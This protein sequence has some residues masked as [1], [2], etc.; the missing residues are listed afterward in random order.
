MLGAG[1][2]VMADDRDIVSECIERQPEVEHDAAAAAPGRRASRPCMNQRNPH[3]RQCRHQATLEEPECTLQI[4]L[5]GMKSSLC[6]MT[7]GPAARVYSLLTLW[8]PLVDQIVLA[9]DTEGDIAT[10]EACGGLADKRFAFE[11]ED[12]WSPE[13]PLAWLHQQCDGEWMIQVD[14]D[15]IP[16]AAL[17]RT[18]PELLEDTMARCVHTP[19]RWL[20]PDAQHY[21]ADEPWAPD[22]HVRILRN[23]PG[24]FLFTG[25]MHT[26]GETMG[27]RRFSEHLPLYHADVL[28]SPVEVRRRKA[29]RYERLRPGHK[30]SGVAVNAMYVPEDFRRLQT[31]RVSDNDRDIIMRVLAPA[32][33]PARAVPRSPVQRVSSEEVTSCLPSR[34]AQ[35][36]FR[37]R[38][39]R[40]KLVRV[41]TRRE[42]V[43]VTPTRGTRSA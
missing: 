28:L 32:D 7:R 12:H 30:S 33:V 26:S 24:T 11:K 10:L 15:E 21:I 13:R 4:P 23:E 18:L 2:E 37:A 5:P 9:V 40:S 36:A 35:T 43:R 17:L 8:R 3:T 27:P 31:E 38:R 42:A 29:N 16:S 34:R 22:W 41:L 25:N 14:D 20:F 19:M 6:L 1:H 39:I